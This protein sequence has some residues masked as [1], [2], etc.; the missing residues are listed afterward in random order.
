MPTT[1][2]DDHP[3][4][5][6]AP[7]D[8]RVAD[9]RQRATPLFDPRRLAEAH[10]AFDRGAFLRDGFWVLP[11]VMGEPTRRRWAAALER[12]Q[13]LQD[14]FVV[15]D[16][17]SSVDWPAAGLEPPPP[18]SVPPPELRAVAQGKSQTL[19]TVLREIGDG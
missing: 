18:G 11:G 6:W 9:G 15:A 14:E 10:A 13:Q 17:A 1:P 16:W 7:R 19:P 4:T 2:A 12:A 3:P 5:A 8:W